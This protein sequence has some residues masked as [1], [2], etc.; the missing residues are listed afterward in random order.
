MRRIKKHP[1]LQSETRKRVNFFFNG[2]KLSAFEGEILSSAL[3]ANGIKIFGYHRKDDAPQGIFCANGQCA[4]CSVMVDGKVEK[5]CITKVRPEMMVEQIR[6]EARC[7]MRQKLPALH[8]AEVEDL[9]TDV[10]IIGAGPAGLSAATELGK[11]NVPAIVVDDKHKLGGKLV[12][13]THKFFGSVE[14]CYAGTRGIHI[15]E[16]LAA[17]VKKYPSLEIWLNSVCLGI[18]SD[19]KAGI[20][21]EGKYC[22]VRPKAVVA[23]SYTHLTLPTN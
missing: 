23:V 11:L 19:K 8:F 18:F 20:L 12:L 7:D 6:G 14:D 4:Q 13:Q 21:K 9:E 5:A 16:R 3:F 2:R 17:E 15:A 22:L 1:I 10:L